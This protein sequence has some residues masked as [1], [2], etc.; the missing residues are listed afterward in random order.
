MAFTVTRAG[1][2]E[3]DFEAYARLLRQQGADLAHWPRVP[4]PEAPDRRWVAAW[5][6]EPDAR[7]FAD[8]LTA[9]TGSA[10]QVRATDAP[11]SHGPLGPLLFH[12][13]RRA[14]GL[15]FA[16]HPLGRAV[17]ADG[18]ADAVPRATS[19]FLDPQTWADFHRAH[20]GLG[21]LIAE[22]AP[23][24]TGLSGEQLAE[25]GY[26]VLDADTGRAWVRVAPSGVGAVH[27]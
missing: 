20:G 8:E 26:A 2:G 5:G 13:A 17:L 19:A 3:A 7:R 4:D 16:L 24:L 9:T 12:L 27:A 15:T 23:V 21:E 1:A 10:W 18:A 25:W 11:P 6:A 22:L 14:D